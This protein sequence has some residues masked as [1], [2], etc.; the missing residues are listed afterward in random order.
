MLRKK[1]IFGK[2]V[3]V[4]ELITSIA[5]NFN[6]SSRKIS[7]I[8][9]QSSHFLIN[10]MKFIELVYVDTNPSILTFKN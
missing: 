7:L 1:P 2:C 8:R 10:F 4:K 6:T 5:G 9:Y 3:Q